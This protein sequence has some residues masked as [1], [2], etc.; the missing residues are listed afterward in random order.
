MIW[1]KQELNL[2]INELKTRRKPLSTK[3]VSEL[4]GISTKTAIK[5]LNS[6]NMINLTKKKINIT[7]IVKIF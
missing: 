4:L 5:Y 2:K 7:G 6:N 3:E 1:S